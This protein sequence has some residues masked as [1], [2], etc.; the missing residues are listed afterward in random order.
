MPTFFMYYFWLPA[1]IFLVIFIIYVN[2]EDGEY[3]F[4]ENFWSILAMGAV[5]L[6]ISGFIFLIT[7]TIVTSTFDTYEGAYSTEKLRALDT[8]EDINGSASMM[9]FVGSGHIGE[10][11]YYHFF[12]DTPNGIKYQKERAEQRNFYLKETNG[13]PKF[14]KYGIFYHTKH[15]DSKF[16]DP[17]MINETKMVLEIPKGTVKAN[18]KVN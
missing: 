5:S 15:K 9:F 11:L 14:I 16:Y 4:W 12:Y 7:S 3:E 1:F 17:Y 6:V 8:N 2:H 18:Y 10:D 13:K